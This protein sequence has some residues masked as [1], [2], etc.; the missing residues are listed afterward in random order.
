MSELNPSLVSLDKGL[1][2][3]TAK[4]VAPA[5]TVLDSLNYEQVDF[6][7]Q[8][9]IDG[10]TRYD[11]GLLPALD[12]YYKITLTTAFV[13]SV[14]DLLSTINGLL[15]IVVG[16]SST[17]VYAAII[18]YNLIPVVTDTLYRLVG[19]VNTSGNVITAISTG[20]AAGDSVDVHY[21]N[22]L[23]FTTALRNRVESLPGN[24]IGLHWFRD[25]LYAVADV[26]A[27]SLSGTTPVLYPNDIIS[28]GSDTA[29]VL[30]S[31]PNASTRT[32]FLNS[33]SSYW[34]GITNTQVTRNGLNVGKIANGFE[35]LLSGDETASFFESRSEQ[36]VL[37]ED[38]P[39]GPYNFGWRFVD[40]GWEIFF[41]DGLSL[42]GS[43]P[44]LNQ[45]IK[46]IGVQGPTSTAGTNGR[47]LVLSQK[48]NISGEPTQINGWKSSQTPLTYELET[49]N[50]TNVDNITIYADAYISWD[51]TTGEVVSVTDP[52]SEYPANNTVAITA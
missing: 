7:G 8:K 44:S 11:G 10:F 48:I 38:G 26:L 21:N 15:G 3:Q 31:I 14:G 45:N 35:T 34:W 36:Q 17:I 24:I 28:V 16:V 29:K 51:G 18:D 52:L 5:G 39:S 40:Q 42:Y 50:L 30:D 13:G 19:G 37:S 20:S 43:L 1:N 47:P 23:T 22:L 25:R 6:Q 41:A 9:R 4:L 33:L 2:L 32:V 27:I 12:D 46:G 49:A